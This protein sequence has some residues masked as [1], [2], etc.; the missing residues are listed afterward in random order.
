MPVL[1][2]WGHQDRMVPLDGALTVLALI[3]DVR[4][5]LWGGGSGHFVEFEHAEEW[6]RMVLDFLRA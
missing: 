3:P 6:C 5:V 1:V 4:V 2:L